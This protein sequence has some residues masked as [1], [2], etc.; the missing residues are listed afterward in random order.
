MWYC[1]VDVSPV[2]YSDSD[3]D[4]IDRVNME[5]NLEMTSNK[6]VKPNMINK[7]SLYLVESGHIFLKLKFFFFFFF[8]F[9][10]NCEIGT[11]G[12]GKG[13]IV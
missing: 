3:S 7:I 11:N 8:F 6:I 4:L 1:Q 12:S 5:C 10:L 2:N 9:F 13:Y